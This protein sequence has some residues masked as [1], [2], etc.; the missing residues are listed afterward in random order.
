MIVDEMVTSFLDN[1]SVH[2]TEITDS[3]GCKKTTNSTHG[4]AEWQNG[5]TERNNWCYTIWSMVSNML[6][7]MRGHNM[8][9]DV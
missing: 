1:N 6:C 9:F 8:S 7:I 5:W 3:A 2:C 4:E